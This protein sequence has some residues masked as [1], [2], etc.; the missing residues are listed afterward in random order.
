MKHKNKSICI[1]SLSFWDQSP[2][3]RNW[4]NTLIENGYKVKVFCYDPPENFENDQLEYGKITH[5][6]MDLLPDFLRVFSRSLLI[7]LIILCMVFLKS[8]QYQNLMIIVFFVIM[9]IGPS[10]YPLNSTCPFCYRD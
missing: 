1:F 10:I 5:I 3:L 8:S 2:R 9:A 6:E 7:S 4:S